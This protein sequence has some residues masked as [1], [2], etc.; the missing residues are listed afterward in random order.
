MS[1]PL[2]LTQAM[3]REMWI[4]VWTLRT[5]GFRDQCAGPVDERIA[6]LRLA[7]RSPAAREPSSERSLRRA[8]NEGKR[9]AQ[10]VLAGDKPVPL[11][12][13]RADL[14]QAWQGAYDGCMAHAA[15]LTRREAT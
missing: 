7:I 11:T 13:H 1:E 6:S 9:A 3:I 15:N 2:T 5:N 14:R 8:R 10:A 4:D 12:Y